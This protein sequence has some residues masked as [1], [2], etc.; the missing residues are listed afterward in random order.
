VTTGHSKQ[1]SI[2]CSTCLA[3]QAL[4]TSKSSY[5]TQAAYAVAKK[6]VNV[7]M[8]GCSIVI[9]RSVNDL[10]TKQGW[11]VSSP[12][13]LMKHSWTSDMNC[14]SAAYQAAP[15]SSTIFFVCLFCYYGQPAM[16][17]QLM[18]PQVTCRTYLPIV[19]SI[20]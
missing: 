20:S 9:A 7:N 12:H 18:L 10:H 4:Q 1:V 13:V 14:L 17:T 3:W 16:N 19:V 6:Q 5:H 8:L 11:G 2:A 15:T